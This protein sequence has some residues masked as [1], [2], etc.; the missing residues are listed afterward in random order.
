MLTGTKLGRYEI[1]QKIGA[2]GMGEVYLAHDEQLDRNIA[3]KI[4]LPEFCCDD[5]RVQRFKHEA[6]AASALN[7]PNIITIHEIAQQDERLYIATEFVDGRTL[8]AKMER[9]SLTLLDSIKIAEQIADALAVAHEAHLVHRDIKPENIMLR[10][11]GYVKI[12]DFGLAKSLLHRTVGTEDQTIQMV[13]TQPGMV[14]GSVRYMSPEQARGKEADERTDV[15]S[16]G[17]VLYEMLTGENPF[18]GE[19]TSDS[20]AAVLHVEPPP[21]ENFPEEL[22]RIIRK[23]LRKKSAER[24]Q[25]IKDFALDLKDLRAQIES[26]AVENRVASSGLTRSFNAADTGESKTLIHETHSANNKTDRQNDEWAKTRVYTKK[27]RRFRTMMPLGT[28]AVVAVLGF[29]AWFYSAS[30]FWASEPKFETIQVNRLTDTGNARLASISP[31]GK[32]VAFVNTRDGMNIL[33]VRQVATQSTV[34]VVAPTVLNYYQPTFSPDGDYIYY[35]QIDK[36]VGTLFQV[37]TL[38]GESKKIVFDVDSKVTFTPKGDQFAFIRHDPT[39]GGDTIFT[40]NA[41]GSNLQPFLHTKDI[42][43]DKFIEA[44]WS[45]DGKKMLIGVFKGSSELVQKMNVVIVDAAD[46]T[47]EP[48][49]QNN[50]VKA[51][52]FQWLDGGS[53]LIFVGKNNMSD[54]MQIWRLSYPDGELRQ[55]SSDT[56]DYESLSL[57]AKTDTMVATKVDSIQSFWSLLPNTRELKQLTGESRNLVGFRGISHT[58]DKRLLFSKKTG[59]EIN[60]FSMNEDGSGEKQLTAGAGVNISPVASPDGK[61][62]VFISN[63][64]GSYELWRMSPDGKNLFRLTEYAAGMDMHPEITPDGKFVFFMR[65]PN[66][67]SRV[68]LMKISIEGGQVEPLMPDDPSANLFPQI[69]PDGKSLAFHSFHYDAATSNFHT[70]VKIVGLEGTEIASEKREEYNIPPDLRWS[71][72]GKALIYINRAGVDNLWSMS[73]TDKQ[74]KAFTEFNSGEIGSFTWSRDGKRLFLIRGVFNGDLVL[75]KDST[76]V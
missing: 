23:A 46:K 17:V 58:P 38:G 36:G 67:G 75:I 3:L 54:T 74:Q 22:Q 20:L 55:V 18:A 49:S 26:G 31:D 56:S 61:N 13:K 11:D 15:W 63:R 34:E 66:D 16:L 5:E 50:W 10:R 72:D 25:S 19:T 60:V 8:R 69:S 53:A 21:L 70:S 68:R 45:P 57:S 35:V 7:H 71:P 27:T 40:A 24:Y 48:L 42:S 62:I 59:E 29:G 52:G 44:V 2:G 37:P 41:D 6:K 32:F 28:L 39:A 12:L 47:S 9:G 43:V 14:M 73:L 65:Q 1:R 30:L 33:T 64:N 76:G 4:L 51:H